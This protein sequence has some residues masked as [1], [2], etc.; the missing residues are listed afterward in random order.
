[1]QPGAFQCGESTGLVQQRPG[2]AGDGLAWVEVAI[3]EV[4]IDDLD[5]RRRGTAGFGAALDLAGRAQ[6]E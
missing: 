5:A 4:R 1:L 6:L 2:E 3:N